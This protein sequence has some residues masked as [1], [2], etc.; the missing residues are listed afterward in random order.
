[1][2][3]GGFSKKEKPPM[4]PE[5]R[6]TINPDRLENGIAQGLKPAIVVNAL[7]DG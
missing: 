1:M 3:K 2:H 4:Q 7:R 6:L 5:A